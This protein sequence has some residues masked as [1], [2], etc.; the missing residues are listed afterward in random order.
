MFEGVLS[1][2]DRVRGHDPVYE[3]H[4]RAWQRGEEFPYHLYSRDMWPAPFW[5]LVL[6]EK[7]LGHCPNCGSSQQMG[8]VEVFPKTYDCFAC[9][10]RGEHPLYSVEEMQMRFHLTP[11]LHRDMPAG[12]HSN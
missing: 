12:L 9:G 8:P 11:R 1:V 6:P 2:I 5:Q 7:V 3:A 10:F 4:L